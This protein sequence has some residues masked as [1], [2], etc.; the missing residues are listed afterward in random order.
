MPAH[1]ERPDQVATP[2]RRHLGQEEVRSGEREAA[3]HSGIRRISRVDNGD[4]RR[5]R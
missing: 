5:E 1:K 4:F 2:A 3:G